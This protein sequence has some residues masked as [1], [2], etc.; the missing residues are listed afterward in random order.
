MRPL[1]WWGTVAV[2]FGLALALHLTLGWAWTLGAGILG[3]VWT[4]RGGWLVGLLGVGLA[5]LA[6]VLYNLAWHADAVGTMLETLGG[7]M[8]GLPGFLIVLLTLL[9]GTLLGVLGGAVGAHAR[10]L[11]RARQLSC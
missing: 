7:I 11:F 9:I 5:W 6:L 4:P 1:G 10:A 8:G 2:T 3:G